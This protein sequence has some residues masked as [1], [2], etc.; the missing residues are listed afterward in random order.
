MSDERTQAT[1][2]SYMAP[3]EGQHAVDPGELWFG[4]FPKDGGGP[5]W[6]A[7]VVLPAPSV[8]PSQYEPPAM[9]LVEWAKGFDGWNGDGILAWTGAHGGPYLTAPDP[10]PSEADAMREA[11]RRLGD[12]ADKAQGY[13]HAGLMWG[14]NE[15]VIAA[16]DLYAPKERGQ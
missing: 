4:L 14:L 2:W 11:L 5:L 3:P 6:V 10:E 16:R 13:G 7:A 15:A 8:P 9:A 1:T 12:L